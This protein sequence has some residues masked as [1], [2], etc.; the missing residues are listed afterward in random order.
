MDK[1]KLEHIINGCINWE[2]ASQE[3]LY[4]LISANLFKVC[5]YYSSD[6]SKAED[7]LHDSFIHIFKN[8]HKYNF[9]GSFEGWARR[10]TVNVILGQLRTQKEW[11]QDEFPLLMEDEEEKTD[12]RNLDTRKVID[13][14]NRLPE[15]A[16][17]VIKLYAVEGWSHSE[18]AEALNISVGTSKSQLNYARKSLK[19]K[20]GI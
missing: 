13:E 19:Q 1:E 5:L 14:I 3:S 11:A 17:L 7:Y 8:I 4:R 12:E 6:H 10:I 15:K 20:F 18:I 16:A 2:R 9:K